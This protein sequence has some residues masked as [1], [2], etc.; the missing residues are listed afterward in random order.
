L[1]FPVYYKGTQ[2]SDYDQACTV[3]AMDGVTLQELANIFPDSHNDIDDTCDDIST[4]S[5]G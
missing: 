1:D 5:I 2:P 4:K 3:L